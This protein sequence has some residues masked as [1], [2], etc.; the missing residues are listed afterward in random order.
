[1][2]DPV[3]LKGNNY[4]LTI[5]L[6]SEMDFRKL[7]QV[8]KEKFIQ[9]KDFFNS[10]KQIAVKI[11]GRKLNSIQM[12]ELLDIISENSSLEI[13]YIIEDDK[14]ADNI[15]KETM[16]QYIHLKEKKQEEANVTSGQFYK[17]TLRSGQ[18][19]E[20]DSSVVVVGDV[21]PGA[22]VMAK[23]N[24]VILGC[25]KGYVYA[26]TDGDEKS[27]IAAL[28]MQPMQVRIGNMIARCSDEEKDR[29][30]K[31]FGRSKNDS[32][33]MEAQIAFVEDGKIYIE[34]ISKAL[35]SEITV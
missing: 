5:V 32:Q 11:E 14:L 25:A 7:K 12:R 16:N 8:V 6:D 17:G 24:V 19:L 27:F 35:L 33:I 4:G 9:A 13:A 26:G 1:M 30:R 10:K 20:S 23:G 18:S 2:K 29:K 3:L 15:F 34:P 28:D 21:N 22:T 31:K